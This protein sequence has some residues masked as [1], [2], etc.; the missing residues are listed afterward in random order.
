VEHEQRLVRELGAPGKKLAQGEALTPAEVKALAEHVSA[1]AVNLAN[2]GKPGTGKPTTQAAAGSESQTPSKT[3]ERGKAPAGKPPSPA[4]DGLDVALDSLAMYNDEITGKVRTSV[5]TMRATI[6]EQERKLAEFSQKE[7]TF[8][9][10]TTDRNLS[11]AAMS[12]L[13]SYPELQQPGVLAEICEQLEK[14]D[15]NYELALAGGTELQELFEN[16]AKLVILPKR[17]T[18][19]RADLLQRTASERQGAPAK[20]PSANAAATAVSY[21]PDQARKEIAKVISSMAP[22][23]DREDRIQAIREQTVK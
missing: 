15:P 9:E 20:P 3:G 18:G 2:Q 16:A 19:H 17:L 5:E 6:A 11:N 22:G 14:W 4:T 8:K 23:K 10:Q 13:S 1:R 21:S 12:V 7:A